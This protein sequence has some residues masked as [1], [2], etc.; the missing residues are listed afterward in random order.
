MEGNGTLWMIVVI[1]KNRS[2]HSTDEMPYNYR[3][4]VVIAA[5][6][7]SPVTLSSGAQS[8]TFD[9]DWQKEL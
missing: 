7:V 5:R 8:E 9:A 2:N 4:A 3:S 1:V 6:H